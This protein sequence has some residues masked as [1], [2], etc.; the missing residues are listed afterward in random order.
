MLIEKHIFSEGMDGDSNPRMISDKAALNIMNCRFGVSKNGRT[1]RNENI[2][3]TTRITQSVVPPYGTNQCLGS[4]VDPASNRMIYFLWNSFA[5]H[6]IYCFDFT[7]RTT[8]AVLYDTQTSDGLNFSKSYRIDRDCCI[9][10]GNLYWC[11]GENNQP[12]H[13]FIDSGIKANHPSYTTDAIAYSFP[14]DNED[15]TIIKPP[16]ALAPNIQKAVDAGFENNFIANESY[17]FT[18]LYELYVG[19][20]SVL[21]TYSP[22]SRLNKVTDTENYIIV[23]MDANQ[24]ISQVVERVHLV[25]RIGDGKSGGGNI[26]FIAKTWD[27]N[28]TTDA[29]EIL[30]QNNGAGTLTFDFY[31]NITGESIAKDYVLKVYD[32]VPIYSKTLSPAK[33]RVFLGNNTEGYDTPT[34]T[35]LSLASTSV[36]IGGAGL[37]KNLISVELSWLLP[38]RSYSAWYVLMTASE[39][40]PAGYYELTTTAQT[41]NSVI[42]PTLPAAPTSIAFSGLTFRGATQN[43]VVT[44][45][46]GSL[47]NPN[48]QIVNTFTSTANVC[49]VTGLSVQTY[50]IFKTASQYK[51]GVVFYDFAMRKCGVVTNDGLLF[52]IPGRDFAFSSGTSTIVW[53][54]TNSSPLT[55]IPDWAY[56]YA[57]VRTLNLKTRFF[58]DGFTNAAKYATKNTDNIYQFTSSTFVT[59]SLGIGLNQTALIQSGLGYTFTE[60]DIC[61]LTMDD[62]T[63]YEFPVVAQD[64]VYVVVKCENIG[65]LSN[66]RIEY[67]LYTPYKTSEQ[68]P[69]YEIGQMYR[70][71]NSGT[72]SRT[73]E[74]LSDIFIPDAYVLTRNYGTNTYFAE[75][76]CPNDRFY[77]RWDNDGGKPNF[78][79]TQGQVQKKT[80]GSY[81]NTYI[82]G[83]NVNGL[84]TFEAFSQ[85]NVPE[86]SGEINKLIL[87][88]KIEDKGTVMLAICRNETNSIYIGEQRISDSTGQTQFFARAGGVIGTIDSLK[89]S[90][91]TI[92]KE[93]VFEYLGLVFWIDVLNGIVAQYSVAGLEPVSRY[94]QNRFFQNYCIGYMAASTGNL[95]NINGFHHIPACIDP[96]HKEALF[97]L[98][99][100]IYE[101]Y[102][103]TLPSFSSVPSYATSIIDRFDIYDQLG[104]TMSYKY[105]EN[106]WGSNYEFM[107]EWMEYFQ[108]TLFGF[109]DGVLY[110]HDDDTTNWNRF[111][112]TDYPMRICFA[113]NA[114]ASLLKD[115]NGISIEG[116]TAPDFTVAMA[117]YPNQQIT[118][119]SAS[120]Y[121][122]QQGIFYSYFLRDRLSGSVSGTAEQKLFTGNSLTD[123]APFIM[124]EIAAYD[125]LAYINFVNISFSAARGQKQIINPI[126]T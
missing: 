57:V 56:Y 40:L 60:G 104:K 81:S 61:L 20:R 86:D 67:Q 63:Q 76:M 36:N 15:I 27:K 45:V 87:T 124:I 38:A 12:R 112:G 115:L 42:I 97:T 21:G 29:A 18:F 111:Y 28:N 110:V 120:K 64:G 54:L 52:E 34:T 85:F 17:E 68:E 65:D 53:T 98:P 126:N 122:D 93:S 46:R 109:K 105:L 69:F 58:V 1:F 43:E 106:N 41:A 73:Y 8:Y 101:N 75:A 11:E 125:S 9:T 22:A 51:F 5:Y 2:P 102:A 95:D 44:Y 30:A 77:Q 74:T 80:F 62:N 84:S 55:E 10:N 99:A 79:T 72:A 25:V 107:P 48:V 39:V 33:N 114:N 7:T 108:N 100:L 23:T 37:N 78:I 123:I 26:A 96:F 50:D 13:I 90:F 118:D 82:P 24:Q 70:I 119:L 117:N 89:G 19:A 14:I 88:Q 16:P 103:N 116:N 4:C 35:S 6:G 121:R 83:T 31:G 59:G 71:L 113:A 66:R 92:S 47:S 3:G 49:Q 91:G 32:S 94:N